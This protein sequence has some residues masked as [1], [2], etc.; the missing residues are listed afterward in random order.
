M[1]SVLCVHIRSNVV[2][3]LNMR[4][5]F[6]NSNQSTQHAW[7]LPVIILLH[8]FFSQIPTLLNVCSSYTSTN[9]LWLI[10]LSVRKTSGQLSFSLFTVIWL[11]VVIGPGLPSSQGLGDAL[12]SNC[13][14]RRATFFYWQILEILNI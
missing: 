13:F 8:V 5:P 10:M 6:M 3:S 4:S 2:I 1:L 12:F 14:A 9:I 11:Y 7:K